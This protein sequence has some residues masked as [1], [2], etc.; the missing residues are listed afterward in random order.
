MKCG[1]ATMTVSFYRSLAAMGYIS[2]GMGQGYSAILMMA[3]RSCKGTKTS[4]G[5]V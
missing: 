4:F 3:L 1:V 5:L 2:S